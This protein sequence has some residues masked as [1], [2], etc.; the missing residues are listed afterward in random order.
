MGSNVSGK[1]IKIARIMQTPEIKQAELAMAMQ[2][3]GIDINKNAISRI[4][5]G[6][7]YVTDLELL[8]I[9]KILKVSILWLLELT[10]DS[11]ST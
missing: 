2:L 1:R 9:A 5:L 6:K 10:D 3:E 8:T 7:R 4:E 11:R